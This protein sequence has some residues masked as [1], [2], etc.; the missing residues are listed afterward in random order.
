MG[1]GMDALEPRLAASGLSRLR[2]SLVGLVD[3]KIVD[4]LGAVVGQHRMDG[5]G[6]GRDEGPKEVA[7]DPARGLLVQL[8]E[9]ELGGAVDGHEEVEPALLGVHLGV[10]MWK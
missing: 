1:E 2:G 5:V 8:G 6:H 9:G 4:E 7:R 3:G 10:A